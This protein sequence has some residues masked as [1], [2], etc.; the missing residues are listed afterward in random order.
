MRAVGSVSISLGILNVPIKMYLSA[1]GEQVSFNMINPET[2]NRVKQL[3]VDADDVEVIEEAD[4]TKNVNV[5]KGAKL[6]GRNDTV[7]GYEYEKGKYVHFTDEEVANMQAEKRDTLDLREFA[8]ITEINP[9]HVE[10]TYYT[11]PDKSDRQY[12]LL[13]EVLGEKGLGAVGTWRARGKEHLVIIRSSEQGLL[14]HQMFYNSEVRAFENK[15]ANVEIDDLEYASC[16]VIIDQFTKDKLDVSSY[17]DTFSEKV[18]EAVKF[19]LA[20]GEI[21]KPTK[22]VKAKRKTKADERAEIRAGFIKAGMPEDKLDALVEAAMKR[23]A[24]RVKKKAS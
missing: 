12:K 23:K 1:K 2:G 13:Q 3:L 19:K 20:G 8:P 4:K 14:I 17:T 24:A 9:L 22:K 11:A 5:N 16:E 7:K 21:K 6:L 10:K 15:C 18:T